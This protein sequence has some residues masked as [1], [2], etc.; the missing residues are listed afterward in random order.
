MLTTIKIKFVYIHIFLVCRNY[1]Q[2]LIKPLV[3][4]VIYNVWMTNC[5][6][7]PELTNANLQT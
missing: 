5:L 6:F 4:I 2:Y 1:M 7:S 3:I